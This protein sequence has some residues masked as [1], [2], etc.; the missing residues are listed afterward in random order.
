MTKDFL[1][2]TT[3]Q[4]KLFVGF[5]IVIVLSVFLSVLSF[6]YLSNISSKRLPT[7]TG[8]NQLNIEFLNMTHAETN[9]FLEDAIDS[10]NTLFFVERRVSPQVA[11]W[12]RHYDT[13]L[14]TL[15]DFEEN[16]GYVPAFGKGQQQQIR[17]AMTRYH[18]AFL[19]LVEH[20]RE[21]G[22]GMFGL[23]GD[24]QRTRHE[25]EHQL[26]PGGPAAELLHVLS[27]REHA[28]IAQHGHLSPEDFT[29]DLDQLKDLVDTDADL[30]KAVEVYEHL[31]MKAIALDDEIGR[32]YDEGLRRSV[33]D[34]VMM[35]EPI[36]ERSAE[37]LTRD[38]G[39][40]VK[41]A[42]LIIFIT[43][44]FTSIVSI[45]F[46]VYFSVLIIS[47]IVR[48]RDV[49]M[50]VAE[51]DLKQQIA[52]SSNDELG[53]FADVFNKMVVTLRKSYQGL[54]EKVRERTREVREKVTEL[55]KLKKR[56]ELATSSAEIGIWEWDVIN[57]VLVWDEMMYRLYGI[58]KEDFSGAYAAWKK[59]V[60]PDDIER[61]DRE[62]QEALDGKTPFNTSFRVVWP[63][64]S[65]RDIRAFGLVERDEKGKPLK[66]VGVNFDITHEKEVDRAKTEFVSLASHQLRTPLTAI[67]WYLESLLSGKYGK[68]TKKQEQ[69]L[70]EIFEGNRHMIELVESLLSVSRI[71]LGTFVLEPREINLQEV[72]DGVHKEFHKE[73]ERKEI[74]ITHKYD[75]SIPKL[76]IDPK[77]MHMVIQ[78]LVSNAIKYTPSGGKI[79]T[80]FED[81]DREL[82]IT[83]SDSGYGIP[84]DEQDKV[85]SKLFRA[86]NVKRKETQGTGL[87]LYIVNAVVEQMG[88]VISFESQEN[89]G[90]T[91]MIRIPLSKIM[92]TKK[93]VKTDKP[94]K[95]KTNKKQK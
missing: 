40:D 76:V 41:R 47:S 83:V 80:S 3:L 18:D 82:V 22:V 4:T 60:H 59:G 2:N 57:N 48:M 63:D 89:K 12:Q 58:D 67:K 24:I 78:N 68:I 55:E 15:D 21:R 20:Q 54:E 52:I 23:S 25:I 5:G 69:S 17:T 87:G 29:R 70:K 74:A 56:L 8:I 77:F 39:Q 73:V 66:M 94:K 88:G 43:S 46:A 9:F 11:T 10:T 19:T 71:E 30:V 91:F 16:V 72:F 28:F 37:S 85:F 64:G 95:K 75:A 35:V 42:E 38:I 81:V 27:E 51:G 44:F 26:R 65:V 49:A 92:S 34:S 45:L 32:T 84:E 1:K 93:G 33:A 62:V 79:E 90:T 53:Q 6:F 36:L 61:S 86:R 14:A 31:L 7:L 50:K 13:F